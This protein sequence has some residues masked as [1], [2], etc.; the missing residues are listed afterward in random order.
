MTDKEVNIRSILFLVVGVLLLLSLVICIYIVHSENDL[1]KTE[2]NVIKVENDTEGTG[3][4]KVTVVYDVDGQSYEYEFIYKDKIKE[5]DKLSIYYHSKE[6][7]S[8]QT[9]KTSKIIFICPLIGLMLCGVGLFELFKH[10]KD[11]SINSKTQALGVSGDSKKI[12]IVTS[13]D[14]EKKVTEEVKNEVV[15]P[16]LP[17]QSSNVVPKTRVIVKPVEKANTVEEVKSSDIPV[18]KVV[19]PSGGEKVFEPEMK[20][21]EQIKESSAPVMKSAS[22]IAQKEESTMKSASEIAK[23]AM[24]VMK[25]ASE[26]VKEVNEVKEEKEEINEVASKVEE[27]LANSPLIKD[28]TEEELK[29]VIKEMLKEAIKE[30]NEEKTVK[31]PVV[32]QRVIPNYFYISGTSLIYE[33]VGKKA[34]E[35]N[36]KDIKSVVRTINSV[37]SVV[38][39]VV[40]NDEIKCVLTNMKNIDLEQLAN[41]LHNK[42]RTI[43]DTFKEVIE[44]KEY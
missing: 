9:F 5:N 12:S 35:I 7:D 18:E 13:D 19:T 1:V 22:E 3:K 23:P 32:Q 15:A 41:L 43:D 33:E 21:A 4:N 30:V 20:S 2:A 14:L 42:M 11:S 37:G 28:K 10:Y 31:K 39:V 34:K 17:T 36:L 6:K 27:T 29:D 25:S 26:A 8:V 24:P 44:R 38:K 16:P 40:S